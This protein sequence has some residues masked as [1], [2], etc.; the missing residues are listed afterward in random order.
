MATGRPA[1]R[2]AP[3]HAPM[4]AKLNPCK[5]GSSLAFRG[6]RAQ[7]TGE[8]IQPSTV[9]ITDIPLRVRDAI[10][11]A[12]FHARGRL[13]KRDAFARRPRLPSEPSGAIRVR[14]PVAELASQ[15]WGRHERGWFVR[16]VPVE[17]RRESDPAH[18]PG[19]VGRVTTW[20]LERPPPFGPANFSNPLVRGRFY[21]RPT[22]PA[23]RPWRR[24]RNVENQLPVSRDS[25][26]ARGTFL[27]VRSRNGNGRSRVSA[28]PGRHFARTYGR[29]SEF[30]SLGS[31]CPT[32][33][34]RSRVLKDSGRRANPPEKCLIISRGLVK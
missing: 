31:C 3:P 25:P 29:G 11:R 7:V 12:R 32:N 13:G 8:V 1:S 16:A 23:H 22:P 2:R 10:A 33:M 17:P 21:S 5:R 4:P 15:G 18:G 19:P 20:L 30:A 28:R 6:R 14:R 27:G 34:G 26:P 9:P 24:Y